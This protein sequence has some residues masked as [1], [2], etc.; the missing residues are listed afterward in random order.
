MSRT[1]FS[2]T[3]QLGKLGQKRI[4]AFSFRTMTQVARAQRS[5]SGLGFADLMNSLPDR[6]ARS[7]RSASLTA[8]ETEG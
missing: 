4:Q 2:R 1:N 5:E 6:A 8:I 7:A 3:P